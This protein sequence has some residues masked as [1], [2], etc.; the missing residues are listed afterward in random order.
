MRIVTRYTKNNRVF[1][2]ATGKTEIKDFWIAVCSVSNECGVGDT[3]ELATEQLF[4]E[5]AEIAEYGGEILWTDLYGLHYENLMARRPV[6]YFN[7]ET[8]EW[9]TSDGVVAGFAFDPAQSWVEYLSEK[10]D[11]HHW[12]T[13]GRL[14][15]HV[16]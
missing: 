10:R 1:D 8:R 6:T 5:F 16:E 9:V 15:S 4:N 14:A 12:R 13:T 3:P 11:D 7:D 2:I